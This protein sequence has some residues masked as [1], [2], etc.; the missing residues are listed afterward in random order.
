MGA[1]QRGQAHRAV[2]LAPSVVSLLSLFPSY[3]SYP[4][5][6]FSL[7][8][9]G[10]AI[11]RATTVLTFTPQGRGNLVGDMPAV[12]FVVNGSLAGVSGRFVPLCREVAARN[13]WTAEFHVTEKAEAGVAAATGSGPRR[14]RPGG[15]GGRGRDRPRLRRGRGVDRRAAR[16][17]PARHRQPAGA[18]ARH[19]RPPA[20][21]ARRRPRPPPGGRRPADR[22]G[23]RRSRA[24]HGDG[25]HGPR[26][27]RGGRDE[28]QA[29]VRLVRL[30]DLGGDPPGQPADAVHDQA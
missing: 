19:P 14:R 23:D 6:S 22:P 3:P 9:G 29:P 28:A 1:G 15:R 7:N 27:R 11:G 2:P 17:R 26:R 16:D 21:G 12:S 8:G 10:P 20:G 5:T 24:V 25:G 4:S 18:D 30:R 13:G